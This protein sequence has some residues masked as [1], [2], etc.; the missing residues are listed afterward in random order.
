MRWR[1]LLIA[2][3][4]LLPHPATAQDK[5]WRVGLLAAGNPRSAPQWIAFDARL[6]ELG[7]VEGR[8]IVTAFRNGEGR[9]D[10]FAA[11]AAELV[12]LKPDL[13]VAP[14]PVLRRRRG[15]VRPR[16]PAPR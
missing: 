16:T 3:L 14:R 2:T 1:S 9:V 13:I 11:H 10:R 15:R 6:R 12:G 4:V 5:A 7:Y 8:S